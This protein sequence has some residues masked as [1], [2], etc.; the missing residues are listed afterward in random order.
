MEEWKK[1]FYS[2]IDRQI[3]TEPAHLLFARAWKRVEDGDKP[4]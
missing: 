4:A 3:P 2:T 1:P